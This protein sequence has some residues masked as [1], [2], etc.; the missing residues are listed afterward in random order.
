[1]LH[2]VAASVV[3]D[4]G[5]GNA[6]LAQLPRRQRRALVAR[7]GF[8]DPHVQGNAR[9]VRLVDGRQRGSVVDGGQPAGIAVGKHVDA[10]AGLLL[11][12]LGQDV[13]A[14]FADGGAAGHVLVADLGGALERGAA[15]SATGI[16]ATAAT[17]SFTAQ[18]RFTAVGRVAMSRVRAA[19]RAGVV[20]SARSARAMP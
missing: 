12:E 14:V 18:R 10:P 11:G 20:A 13:L 3:G 7:P 5:V 6:M 4:H 9:V 15:R 19:S 1:V 2:E 8:V 16:G 17:I